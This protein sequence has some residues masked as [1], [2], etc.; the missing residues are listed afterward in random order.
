MENRINM[1]IVEEIKNSTDIKMLKSY[2][3]KVLK[4]M[5]FNSKNDISNLAYVIVILYI[6]DMYKES[7]EVARLAK[8]VKFTGNYTI[9]DWIITIRMFE[10]NILGIL[11]SDEEANRVLMDLKPTLCP[12]LYEN[13]LR[14]IDIFYERDVQIALESGSKSY[15][16]RCKLLKFTQMMYCLEAP[17]FPCDKEKMREDILALK[18][19]LKTMI[20]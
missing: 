17:D 5:S 19:E 20:K 13:R 6:F 4:K 3:N 7:L 2:C 8:D 14:A 12:E 11:G 1:K 15:I 9:W 18:N 10:I 16:C